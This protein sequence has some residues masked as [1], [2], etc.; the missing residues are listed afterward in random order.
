MKYS[1]DLFRVIQ[2]EV[3]FILKKSWTETARSHRGFLSQGKD[4]GKFNH[5]AC[6]Y[7]RALLT[8]K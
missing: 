8:V 4:V 1:S 6:S 3:L 7:L 5:P 2:W